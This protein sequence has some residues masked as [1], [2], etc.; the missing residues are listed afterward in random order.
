M[1]TYSGPHGF[2]ACPGFGGTIVRQGGRLT[3]IEAKFPFEETVDIL[4]VEKDTNVVHINLK[5]AGSYFGKN[6]GIVSS[7]EDF[8]EVEKWM[9]T[10]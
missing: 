6:C 2:Q 1:A 9:I 7:M 5:I 4:P 10:G 3:F 8:K